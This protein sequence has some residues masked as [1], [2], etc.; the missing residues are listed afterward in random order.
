MKKWVKRIISLL[1]VFSAFISWTSVNALAT[2]QNT[3]IVQSNNTMIP[4]LTTKLAIKK[5]QPKDHDWPERL[6]TIIGA[7]V[8]LSLV[9]GFSFH[10]RKIKG[11]EKEEVED[12]KE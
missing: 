4:Q 2:E 11:V 12:K 3:P 5:W 7:S 6:Y 1:I 9:L 10:E 8:V